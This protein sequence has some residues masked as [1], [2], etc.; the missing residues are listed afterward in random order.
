MKVIRLNKGNAPL[1]LSSDKAERLTEK[2]ISTNES[3]WN[4]NQIKEP[5]YS[6]SNCKCAYCEC[7]LQRTDSYCEIEH[8]YPKSI[9]PKKVL[10]WDNLLPSCKRC[11]IS[12]SD[13]DTGKDT[14]VNPYETDPKEHL[15]IQACRL[16]SKTEI[17]NTTINVL[18]LNDLRL[19][20]PRFELCNKINSD[21]EN[22]KSIPDLRKKRNELKNLLFSC[23][24]IGEFSAFCSHTLH[25]NK[26]Y[27]HIKLEL[28]EARYWDDNLEDLDKET[29]SIALDSR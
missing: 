17:G 5:L 16:Y 9:Y 3:V 10:E 22:L 26:D 19:C 6:S 27:T 12:K 29:A 1:Y 8:F 20:L 2:F 4:K 15:T 14:I 11:N 28:Q 7:K 23:S 18:N 24:K 21:L 25:S 13:H